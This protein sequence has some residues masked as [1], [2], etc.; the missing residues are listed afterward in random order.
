MNPETTVSLHPYF[1]PAPGQ[2][3]N[4]RAMLP[5]LVAKASSEEKCH[6]YDFTI[7]GDVIFCRE[8]YEGAEGVLAHLEN[9]GALVG[10]VLKTMEDAPIL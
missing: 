8:A 6:Y 1:R 3:G 2:E 5:E 4:M 9:V 10:E 7:Q